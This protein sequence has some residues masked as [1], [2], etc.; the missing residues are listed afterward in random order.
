MSADLTNYLALVQ[1]EI[2][3]D[4]GSGVR[5]AVSSAAESFK[6]PASELALQVLEKRAACERARTC[7]PRTVLSEVD[8]S[9]RAACERAR[10]RLAAMAA[11]DNEVEGGRRD[12]EHN[13]KIAAS[14]HAFYAEKRKQADTSAT[15]PYGHN[16]GRHKRRTDG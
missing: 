12:P 1:A 16:V 11:V 13:D 2:G 10:V 15:A 7:Q 9:E 6:V 5:Y 4:S 14:L 3:L 8:K